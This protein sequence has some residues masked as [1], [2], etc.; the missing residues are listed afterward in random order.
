MI[1]M[2]TLRATPLSLVQSSLIQAKVVATNLNGSSVESL[3]NSS[4]AI[5]ETEPNQVAL[6]TQGSATSHLQVQVNWVTPFN[7]NSAI[8]SYAIYWD[9]GTGLNAYVEVAGEASS[10][11]ATTITVTSNVVVGKTYRFKIKAQNK[12]GWGVFSDPVSIL[13]ANTPA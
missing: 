3:P 12:W 4:G 1:E 9:Q 6:P 5:V 13:A 10:F 7:G 11:T 2:S 8:T